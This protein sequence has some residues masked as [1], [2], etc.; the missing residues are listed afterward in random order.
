MEKEERKAMKE[1]NKILNAD[2]DSTPSEP[3][4]ADV[5]QAIRAVRLEYGLTAEEV[6]NLFNVNKA[7]ISRIERN[8]VQARKASKYWNLFRGLLAKDAF[9]KAANKKR[10]KVDRSREKEKPVDTLM[11][12]NRKR[13][14]IYLDYLELGYKDT[15]ASPADT[16]IMLKS[17]KDGYKENRIL[18]YSEQHLNG[19]AWNN[20]LNGTRN[21]KYFLALAN[22]LFEWSRLSGYAEV[23]NLPDIYF[24]EVLFPI[25]KKN[26]VPPQPNQI[27]S[28]RTA[29]LWTE[30]WRG[31]IS[32]AEDKN[33]SQLEPLQQLIEQEE[34][35][36]KVADNQE[37]FIAG[38]DYEPDDG[39]FMPDRKSVV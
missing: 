30:H 38:I 25:Y 35:V 15:G 19:K 7:T 20:I 5:G 32:L 27:L 23:K 34:R 21:G 12:E 31:K 10:T 14:P 33:Q 36:I 8:P 28:E 3:M 9:A 39:D 17:I 37:E 24:R 29:E 11:R 22:Y 1:K 18:L 2:K 16:E 6:G 13:K 26:R 4:T